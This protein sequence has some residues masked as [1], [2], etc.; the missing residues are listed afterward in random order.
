MEACRCWSCG[1][2]YR[3]QYRRGE[4]GA[5][6]I[7]HFLGSAAVNDEV[8]AAFTSTVSGSPTFARPAAG[9]RRAGIPSW[10]LWRHHHVRGR[11]FS[12]DQYGQHDGSAFVHRK[13][14]ASRTAA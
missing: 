3:L 14:F 2:R 13:F 5:Q 8:G 12:A 10:R 7:A 1:N 11:Q 6:A 4:T 9:C